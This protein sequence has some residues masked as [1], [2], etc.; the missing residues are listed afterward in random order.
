MTQQLMDLKKWATLAEGK[1]V[2]FNRDNPRTVR[3]DVNTPDKVTLWIS[4]PGHDAEFLALVEG[5]DRL[6]FSVDGKFELT[7]DGGNCQFYTVDG[8]DFSMAP[9]DDTIFTKV[10]ERRERNR[11][12]ELMMYKSQQ[13]IERRL[14]EMQVDM[15]RSVEK[16]VRSRIAEEQRQAAA[17]AAPAG[18][19]AD[20]GGDAKPKSDDGAKADAA[21]GAASTA[22]EPVGKDA[23][24]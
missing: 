4:E 6:E 3:L 12:V 16:R 1:T 5:R 7:V 22:K 13:N 8:L 21:K 2:T 24:S 17:N 19:N 14:A 23:K 20:A 11:D 10:V 18:K 9:T 15:E